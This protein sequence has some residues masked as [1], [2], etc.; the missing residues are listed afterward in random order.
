MTC[1]I[2][3]RN[4][5]KEAKLSVLNI[6]SII[7]SK[8]ERMHE[9]MDYMYLGVVFSAMISLVPPTYI[10]FNS[11]VDGAVNGDNQLPKIGL[12]ENIYEK[13]L[14]FIYS[15]IESTYSTLTW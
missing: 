5:A 7:I 3:H 2:W 11:V 10:F 4:E 9:S 15:V 13:L 8:V 1:L 12:N 6:S 14:S